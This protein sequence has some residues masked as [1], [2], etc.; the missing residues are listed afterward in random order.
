MEPQR[1]GYTAQ[2]RHGQVGFVYRPFIDVEIGSETETRRFKALVD[3]GTEITVIDQAIAEVLDIDS[4][5]C[6]HGELS[7][8]GVTS[9]G[10]LAP[11]SLKVDKFDRVFNFT[12]LFIENLSENFD[13]ILGQQDFFLNFDITF[14][15]SENVFYLQN[16]S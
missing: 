3:S 6:E 14:K 7:A 9:K 12:V 1:Y 16:V 8:L 5:N 11:V 10:F 4:K 15:K 2:T 13:I